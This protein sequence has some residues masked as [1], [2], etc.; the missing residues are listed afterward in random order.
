M[1]DVLQK[2]LQENSYHFTQNLQDQLI[3]YLELL[4]QWN[5]LFNLTAVRDPAESVLLHILDSLAIQNY[6]YGERIIDVGTGAGLPGI[7]LA[8]ALPE[9][10]FF[11]LDSN[12]KK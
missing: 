5:R 10:Q 6:L 9:K 11:L 12:G 1:K 2:L 4:H 3:A 8:L 7:P